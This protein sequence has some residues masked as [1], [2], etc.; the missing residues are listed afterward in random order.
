[1]VVALATVAALSVGAPAQAQPKTAAEWFNLGDNHYNLGEFD[2]AID[3]FRKAFEIEKDE[4]L[5]PIYLYNI[6]QSYRQAGDCDNAVFFY[7]RFLSLKA[8]DAKKPLEQSTK[9]NILKRIAEQEKLCAEKNSNRDKPPEG[10]MRPDNGGTSGSSAEVVPPALERNKPSGGSPA[11]PEPSGTEVAAREEDEASSDDEGEREGTDLAISEAMARQPKVLSLRVGAGVGIPNLD[12]V[13]VA[14]QLSTSL[15][16]GVPDCAGRYAGGRPWR[17]AQ[18]L[19]V[20]MDQPRRRHRDLAVRHCGGQRRPARRG[21]PQPAAARRRRRRRDV[22]HQHRRGQ[23]LHRRRTASGWRRAHHVPRP[24]RRGGRVRGVE[25]LL[26]VGLAVHV[27]LQPGQGRAARG[28]DHA[29]IVSRRRRLSHVSA[30]GRAGRRE[31]ALSTSI[32][33]DLC[34]PQARALLAGAVA[35]EEMPVLR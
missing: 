15:I 3:A 34:H 30:A 19:A 25:E 12:P 11:R 32:S 24:R 14:N 23:S 29:D 28:F 17:G 5:K 27:R 10:T 26:V 7:K 2:K 4:A 31:R 21:D 9:D 35:D 16:G 22:L 18:L 13:S 8:N 20:A 1:M 6:A 33:R